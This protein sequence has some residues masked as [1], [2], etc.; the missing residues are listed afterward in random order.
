MGE[1]LAVVGRRQ[2]GTESE[3]RPR[4]KQLQENLTVD[5]GGGSHQSPTLERLG[6]DVSSGWT[7]H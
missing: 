2:A 5:Q 6:N 4:A 1:R 7:A 3:E